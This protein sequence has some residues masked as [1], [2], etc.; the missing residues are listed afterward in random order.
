MWPTTQRGRQRPTGS[1]YSRVTLLAVL[2]APLALPAA[3]ADVDF[4]RDIR[5][6]LSERCFQCHGPDEEARASGLRLDE[7]AGAVE[8]RGGKRAI[9]PGAPA[10]SELIARIKTDDPALRM[11]LGG[12]RLAEGQ[13][14]LL[15]EWISAGA[16]YER[17]WAYE[18]PERPQLPPV[19]D[20]G[21]ARN[22]IDRF[23]LNKLDATG[24][25]PASGAEPA[26]LMRRLYLDLIGI[27]PSPEQI[28]DF[29]AGPT[30][31]AY[32]AKVDELLGSPQY[33]E[34]W[35]RHWLDLARHADSN[36]YQHDDL[37]EIWP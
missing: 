22:P 34:H 4:T 14:K 10:A 21:W 25:K 3:N 9:A 12:D 27:P 32:R 30:D 5:P 1:L 23:I 20:A 11:P 16:K 18:K 36:G 7:Y 13:I 15:E 29:L 8:E 28:E 19:S 31:K 26:V 37:R 6:I 2:L 24:L 17:H 35:A 33:G